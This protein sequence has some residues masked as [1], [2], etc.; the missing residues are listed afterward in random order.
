MNSEIGSLFVI[1]NSVFDVHYSLIQFPQQILHPE[2]ALATGQ[3]LSG[4]DGPQGKPLA[5]VRD[6]ASIAERSGRRAA[7]I[8]VGTVMMKKSQAESAAA[9]LS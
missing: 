7:S 2:N 9:S 6:A 5:T 3:P 8:G 4:D 1:Q